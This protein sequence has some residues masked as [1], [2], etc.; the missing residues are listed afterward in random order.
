M[1]RFT[2]LN[3]FRGL[4]ALGLV[5]HHSRIENSISELAL[6]RNASQ[7]VGFFFALS[8]FFLYRRYVDSLGTSRQLGEFVATRC[9][10][11]LPMHLLVLLFF[12]AFETVK[13]LLE[14]RGLAL[15]YPAFSGDRAVTEILPNL[16]LLQAWLP[17]A[18]ALS[19]N[20]PAW[21]VSVGFYLW[22]LFGVLIHVFGTHARKAF[23]VLCVL[24]FLALYKDLSLLPQQVWSGMFCFFGGAITYRVYARLR[25]AVPGLALASVMEVAVLIVLISVMTEG[26]QPLTLELSLLFCIAILIFAQGAGIVSHLLSLRWFTSLGRL[27]F[28]IYMTHAAVIMVT[29]IGMTLMSRSTGYPFLVSGKGESQGATVQYLSTGSALNDNLLLLLIVIAVVVISMW[30]YAWVERPGMALGKHLASGTLRR[31]RREDTQPERA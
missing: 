19:F 15:N 22:L 30:T 13:W 28:S 27:W 2:A 3:S 6:F 11:V 14:Q 4:C 26:Q 29:T 16:L 9:T 5:V 18:N 20:Y 24:A 23:S 10:R 17:N 12:L 31:R 21:F 25:D 8:G 7:F 1:K